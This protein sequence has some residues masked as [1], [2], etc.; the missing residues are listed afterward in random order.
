MI[1]EKTI[2]GV[3]IQLYDTEAKMFM[4]QS[5]EALGNPKYSVDKNVQT[6]VSTMTAEL[7]NADFPVVLVQPEYDSDTVEDLGLSAD[8][9]EKAKLHHQRKTYE[10]LPMPSNYHK[11]LENIKIDKKV[12]KNRY[13]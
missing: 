4:N 10:E 3:V 8:Q 6:K 2:P 1:I 11:P 5:F 7:L 9:T 13:I 12:Y